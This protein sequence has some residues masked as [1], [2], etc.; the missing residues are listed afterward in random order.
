MQI[1]HDYGTTHPSNISINYF[2]LNVVKL[3]SCWEFWE[4]EEFILHYT[5]I[6]GH[7]KGPGGVSQKEFRPIRG[8][9]NRRK[10]A[11]GTKK[12]V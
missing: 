8:S 6:W 12:T 10:G 7:R 5:G 3:I 9:G 11:L 1:T 4:Q 2:T